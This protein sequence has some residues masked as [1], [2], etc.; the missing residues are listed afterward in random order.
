MPPDGYKEKASASETDFNGIISVILNHKDF[1]AKI[2]E[3]LSNKTNIFEEVN[4]IWILFN[5]IDLC[6]ELGNK[7]KY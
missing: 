5:N 6:F 3:N 7:T 4:N 1:Q 2:H